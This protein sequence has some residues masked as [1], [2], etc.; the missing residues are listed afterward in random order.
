MALPSMKHQ[1]GLVL[2]DIKGKLK[3]DHLFKG[4]LIK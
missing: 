3:L 4:G 2:Y 1:V